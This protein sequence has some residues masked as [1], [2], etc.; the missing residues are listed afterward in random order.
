MLV[1]EVFKEG[2]GGQR[3]S[4]EVLWLLTDHQGTVRDIF[5]DFGIR[6]KAIEY[7]AFGNVTSEQY[8]DISGETPISST[9]AEAVDQLFYYTGQE[10]D[11]TTGLQLH[12]ARWYDPATGRW[13][14]E[15]PSGF[16]G[17]DPNLYRYVGNSPPNFADPTGTTQAGNPLTSLP[18]VSRPFANQ[19]SLASTPSRSVSA[20]PTVP[21]AV[22]SSLY[23]VVPEKF[24]YR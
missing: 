16:D 8:F 15:D 13:L 24:F 7:D 20:P 23:V 9:H 17:G 21:A 4:D 6:R 3:V 19:A 18:S 11:A 22:P 10:R 2:A 14:S 5:D 12:G 1:D